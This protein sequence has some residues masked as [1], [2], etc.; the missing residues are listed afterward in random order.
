MDPPRVFTS[1]RASALVD[2]S[3]HE[4]LTD[5]FDTV[6]DLADGAREMRKTIVVELE[7]HMRVKGDSGDFRDAREV[8][9][10]NE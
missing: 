10:I 1:G 3:F 9:A 7:I 8:G 4:F 5:D 2:G 6:Q